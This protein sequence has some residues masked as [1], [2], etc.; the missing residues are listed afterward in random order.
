MLI[1]L[2][3][4]VLSGEFWWEYYM[5]KKFWPTSYSILRYKMCQDFLDIQY[6]V[7]FYLLDPYKFSFRILILAMSDARVFNFLSEWSDI[8]QIWIWIPFL[9]LISVVTGGE[10][11]ECV[12]FLSN[13]SQPKLGISGVSEGMVKGRPNY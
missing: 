1:H 12:P 7:Q 4:V 11:V 2:I 10:G 9:L 3:F 13:F 6:N 8:L 5:S